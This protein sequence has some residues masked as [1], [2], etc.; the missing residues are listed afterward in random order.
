MPP[1]KTPNAYFAA[2]PKERQ[3]VL[4][5]VRAAIK[6]AMP[7]AEEVISYGIVGYVVNGRRTLY[8]SGWKSHFAL[9]P[10]GNLLE[11]LGDEVR[12]YIASKGTLKFSY[13]EKPPMGLITRIA[14]LR[15]KGYP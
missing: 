10:V 12:P 3:P 14:R 5:K 4:K 6:K 8:L 15:S 7:R 9:Y 11:Q 1:A 13:D 2:Q